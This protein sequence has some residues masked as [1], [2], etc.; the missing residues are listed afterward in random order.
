MVG[1]EKSLPPSMD[2]GKQHKSAAPETAESLEAIIKDLVERKDKQLEI[3]K[4][5]KD[6]EKP[7][8]SDI[9]RLKFVIQ[10]YDSLLDIESELAFSQ[11]KW[12]HPSLIIYVRGA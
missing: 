12:I 4:I 11:M 6:K 5:F 1:T 9:A 10:A 2:D 3:V 8:R 7:T